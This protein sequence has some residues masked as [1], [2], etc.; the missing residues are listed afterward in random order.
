VIKLRSIPLLFLALA[1]VGTA[2]AQLT[3]SLNLAKRQYLAGEP[4]IAVVTITNHAGQELTFYGDGRTQWLDFILK[5][6]QGDSVSTK[7]KAN[8]GKMTIRAGESLAREV[9]LSQQFMLSEPGNYSAVAVV[10]M[11]G[12][13]GEGTSTNRVTFNQSPGSPYWTQKVGI[14]GGSGQ[15]R[16]FRIINF[17][18]DQK[19]QV[20]AQVIDGRTGRNVRTFLLGDVLMLRKPLVTVDRRQRMHVL[21]LATPTMW[22]HCQIDTDGKLV[23]RQIHQRGT[24]GDPQL[25]TFPDGEVRVANSIPY[26]PKAAAEAKSKIRKASDRPPGAY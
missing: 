23:D 9:D 24:N 21:F 20:Y 3:A 1:L 22:V 6:S 14:A 18:G 15:L 12:N 8:F 16:E 26:D 4:V 2:H 11:P 10:H 13:P 7:G 17:S 25:L 5:N 19:T